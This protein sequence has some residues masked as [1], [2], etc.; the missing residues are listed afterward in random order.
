MKKNIFIILGCFS[1]AG[2]MLGPKKDLPSTAFSP[3]YIEK[4]SV[5]TSEENTE[6]LWW[7]QF[8]DPTLNHLI[9]I[10]LEENFDLK[11]AREKVLELRANYRMESADLWP[12]INTFGSA[13]RLKKPQNILGVP[14]IGNPYQNFYVLG[15]DAS[16]EIDFF[17]QNRSA[18][19]AA[20]FNVLASEDNIHSTQVTVVSEVARLYTDIRTTQQRIYALEKK[21][22]VQKKILFLAKTLT[23]SGLSDEV[24]LQAEMAEAA[25]YKSELPTLKSSLKNSIYQLTFLLGKSP[26]EIS[27]VLEKRKPIPV[28]FGKIPIGLPSDLLRRRPDIRSAEKH[29]FASCSKVGEARAALFP[30]ISLTA[31]L[32]GASAQWNNI[33][34]K[35][36][37]LWFVWPTVNW[38]IFQG[39]KQIANVKVQKSK[40][41]QALI[42]Y[43]QA[44]AQALTDVESSLSAYAE[45]FI[46]FS[47]LQKQLVSKKKICELNKLLVQSGL[48]DQKK[49]LK[50][51]K[52]F[53]SIQDA[54]FQSKERYMANLISVY[55]ALGGGW[56]DSELKDESVARG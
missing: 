14:T 48:E 22:K 34:S 50:A 33:F 53:Y 56:D 24:S 35:A 47:E 16:W 2:C 39:W 52:D 15:F 4:S 23:K 44:I 8:H 10:A 32:A 42:S 28:A 3:E 41:R 13:V 31:A 55:K 20:Y 36:S 7:K 12:S 25:A 38:N 19:Q 45:E 30:N 54:Y 49:R 37:E 29:Y 43:E 11:M 17:G 27:S 9:T 40:Q 1:L 21:I 18:K 5:T 6:V 51:L 26:G 46:T